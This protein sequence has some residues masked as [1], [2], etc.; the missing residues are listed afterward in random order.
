MP[1]PSTSDH[2]Y[3]EIADIRCKQNVVKIVVRERKIGKKHIALAGAR[4]N[5]VFDAEC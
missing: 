2:C 1:N 3:H 5:F 4:Q